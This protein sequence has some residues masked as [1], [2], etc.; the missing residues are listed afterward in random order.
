MPDRNTVK[1]KKRLARLYD[2]SDNLISKSVGINY[3]I[4]TLIRMD[5]KIVKEWGKTG[6]EI[7]T[8]RKELGEVAE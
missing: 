5:K 8:I 4:K 1:L 7:R 2:R 6:E 3:V